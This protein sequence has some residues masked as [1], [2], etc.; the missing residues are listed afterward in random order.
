[1]HSI[2]VFA[3]MSFVVFSSCAASFMRPI[4]SFLLFLF[5]FL[6]EEGGFKRPKILH[7]IADFSLS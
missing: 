6:W 1:M 5:I 4:I 2:I 3:A 7:K